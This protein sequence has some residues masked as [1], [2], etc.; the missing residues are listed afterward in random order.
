[1]K[2]SLIFFQNKNDPA[3]HVADW[4]FYLNLAGSELPMVSLE[5]LTEVL[6]ETPSKIFQGILYRTGKGP[7][8]NLSRFE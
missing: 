3:Y 8:E 4:K 7:V 6:E 5:K 1:M 2:F